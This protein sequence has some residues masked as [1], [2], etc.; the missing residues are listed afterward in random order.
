MRL[1][2]SIVLKKIVIA[3]SC[4]CMMAFPS[5]ANTNAIE[6]LP[7]TE[8]VS[9]LEAESISGPSSQTETS[10]EGS[11]VIVVGSGQ[12][13]SSIEETEE[14]VNLE[15]NT[16]GESYGTFKT[17]AYCGCVKC[18]GNNNLTYS[19]T[20]PV[21]NHT[22]SADLDVFP[23]G[24]KLMIGDIIYTVEDMGSGVNGNHL[25]IYFDT[26]QQALDYGVKYVEVFAVN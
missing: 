21:A 14:V 2:V 11:P 20:V 24:T 3:S 18:S 12:S 1:S 16:R 13:V 5:L 9:V 23:I 19:G 15:E 4:I 10:D 25:D 7:M 22:I 8:T 17:S 6:I 26:H